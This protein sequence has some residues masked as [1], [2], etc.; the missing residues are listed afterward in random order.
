L[1]LQGVGTWLLMFTNFVPISL[2]VTL[3]LVKVWQGVFIQ[4]DLNMLDDVYH[5]DTVVNGSN[6]NEELGQVE[7][8]LSDKTGTLTRNEMELMWF[9]TDEAVYKAHCMKGEP[10]CDYKWAASQSHCC[11]QEILGEE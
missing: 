4:A 7:Y 6:L 8:I 3:D 11:L 5:I 10:D 1:S 2:L 9:R